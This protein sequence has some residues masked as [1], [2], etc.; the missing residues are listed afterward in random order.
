MELT[1][2]GNK[3]FMGGKCLP[4]IRGEKRAVKKE[5]VPRTPMGKERVKK[6]KERD[7]IGGR[8]SQTNNS[9]VRE[10]PT[11]TS[12]EKGKG[13]RRE[14][15]A[16]ARTKST[17]AATGTALAGCGFAKKETVGRVVK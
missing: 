2:K 9:A 7:L 12:S 1:E 3:G 11:R 16:L 10:P 15:K 14:T 6:K 8:A 5:A 13:S 4:T 17:A